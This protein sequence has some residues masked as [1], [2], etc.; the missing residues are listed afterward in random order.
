MTENHLD[1][2]ENRRYSFVDIA[3]IVIA[4][5]GAVTCVVGSIAIYI[6]QAQFA[7]GFLWPLPGL[8]LLL[9][10]LLGLLSSVAAYLS[11]FRSSIRW[12]QTL[13]FLTG[14][15]IPLIIIGAFSIGSLVMIGFVF[16]L[17]SML[18][19]AVRKKA[20]FLESFGLLMLGSISNLMLLYII[21]TLGGSSL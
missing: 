16:F 14:A 18:I 10:A 6:S 11:F 20:K 7:G 8:V 21:I 12:L 9:W 19:L 2:G 1:E 13:I 15:F 4:F 5:L 3:A 17:V